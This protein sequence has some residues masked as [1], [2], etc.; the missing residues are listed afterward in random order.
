MDQA[1]QEL[2]LR[3]LWPMLRATIF[4]T[5]PLTA[6]SFVLGLVL[7]L[8]VALA[9]ISRIK[10]LSLLARAYVSVIRGTPLL[11]QLF[12]VFYALPQFDIVIDPFPAA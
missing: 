10:P 3:N 1:T 6:V 2:I 12:I 5:I 9:R 4:A 8:L 11:V 7:A